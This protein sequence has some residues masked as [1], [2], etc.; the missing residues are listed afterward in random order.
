MIFE[1]FNYQQTG[2]YQTW[3]WVGQFS[4][5]FRKLSQTNIHNKHAMSKTT[6]NRYRSTRSAMNIAC[7]GWWITGG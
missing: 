3:G 2:I 7:L 4:M 6:L 1:G 5:S